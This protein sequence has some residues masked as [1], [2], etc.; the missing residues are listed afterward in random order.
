MR[1]LT[2]F[3]RGYNDADPPQKFACTFDARRC[4]FIRVWKN[5]LATREKLWTDP[6]QAASFV[7]RGAAH[8]SLLL[9]SLSS[10]LCRPRVKWC[11]LRQI[12]ANTLAALPLLP[13]L[14]GRVPKAR[15][16]IF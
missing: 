3:H 11:D 5:F 9:K 7:A 1:L 13:C 6:G 16:V 12:F 4:H 14:T 2:F 10:M 8:L 15:P